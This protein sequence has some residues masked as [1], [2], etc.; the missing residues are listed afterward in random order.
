M[1]V[2][3]A[4]TMLLIP[5][6]NEAETIEDVLREAKRYLSGSS[7]L[8]DEIVVVDDASTDR[9]AGIVADVDGV[10]LLRHPI[11]RGYGAAQRTGHLYGIRN[12]FDYIVQ[13]DADGQHDPRDIPSLLAAAHENGYDILLGS[14]FRDDSNPDSIGAVRRLG[15]RF[16]SALV[17]SLTGV[18]ITDVTSGFKVYTTTVLEELDRPN[19][20]HPALHQVLEACVNEYAVGEYPVEM[21]R[22]EH[23]SSHLGAAGMVRYQLMMAEFV[24]SVLLFR[25]HDDG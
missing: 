9:T 22:R 10:T 3:D 11:N 25:R 13:C 8:L 21:R 20:R 24:L 15:V 7:N 17:R 4:D 2:E 23:G 6:Y 14:R 1:P 5:A 19:D 16:Y 18:E 12:G